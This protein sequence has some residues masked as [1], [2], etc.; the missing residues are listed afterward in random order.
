MPNVASSL[1]QGIARYERGRQMGEWTMRIAAILVAATLTASAAEAGSLQVLPALDAPAP[2]M[3]VLSAQT[4]HPSMIVLGEPDVSDEQV[5]SI[6]AQQAS[7]RKFE[8][9]PV[10]IRGG[11][12]ASAK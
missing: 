9:Q 2:S 3:I 11:T 1:R 7:R 12:V 4:S 5:A 10:M 8:P 6:G